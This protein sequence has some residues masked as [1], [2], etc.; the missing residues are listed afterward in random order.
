MQ[1][2]SILF[3]DTTCDFAE[4]KKHTVLSAL[5][6]MIGKHSLRL[7]AHVKKH[8]K[9]F[10][11]Y[12]FYSNVVFHAA[13]SCAEAE[14]VK[15]VFGRKVKVIVAEELYENEPINGNSEIKITEFS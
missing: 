1:S 11:N 9:V 7:K 10:Q 8:F 3:F 4:T 13:K 15:E 6:R 12:W 14:D 5:W 2:L